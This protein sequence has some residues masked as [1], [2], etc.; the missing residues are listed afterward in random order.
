MYKL[1]FSKRK[2]KK[3][4]NMKKLR[5]NAQQVDVVSS[6]THTYVHSYTKICVCELY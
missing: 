5:D 4:R 2:K 1:L 6:S 3:N